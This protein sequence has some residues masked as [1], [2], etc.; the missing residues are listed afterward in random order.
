[1]SAIQC[2]NPTEDIRRE[3]V[4]EANADRRPREEF[5]GPTW[6]TE[7][8][9][10]DFDVIGFMAPFVVVRRRSDG[11]EGSLLFRHSPR[12]YYGWEEHS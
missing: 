9:R 12:V 5:D 8:L 10:R 7:E 4:A 6:D 11:C 2:T 3:M 1:M